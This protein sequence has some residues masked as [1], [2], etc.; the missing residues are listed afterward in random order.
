[1][2]TAASGPGPSCPRPSHLPRRARG[3]RSSQSTT[4][5]G[6]PTP[7]CRSPANSAGPA[8]LRL[9]EPAPRAVFLG[10]GHGRCLRRRG[11]HA[12]AGRPYVFAGMCSTSAYIA[13]EMA[14]QIRASG[15]EVGLV[16]LL[17]PRTP[18]SPASARAAT[19]SSTGRWASPE[20]MDGLLATDARLPALG[21]ELAK[22]VSALGLQPRLLNPRRLAGFF[23]LLAA[24]YKASLAYA[25]LP[26][27]GRAAL[28]VPA[29]STGDDRFLSVAKWH[30]L[31]HASTCTRC[32]PAVT[33]S[34]RLRRSKPRPPAPSRPRCADHRAER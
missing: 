5:R 22:L 14:Q 31:V 11:V 16:V 13:C 29:L 19:R 15:E 28:F 24:N 27:P 18:R 8:L 25:P 33:S 30:T 3:R 6:A 4:P 20:G 12:A 34:T 2:T 26:Y 21:V 1:M 32:P 23:A 9:P 7:T 10:Q 17:D